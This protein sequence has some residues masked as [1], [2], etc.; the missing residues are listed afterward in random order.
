LWRLIRAG[1]IPAWG[2]PKC[3]R[4]CSKMGGP[5][6]SNPRLRKP[7]P[8]EELHIEWVRV[9]LATGERL[10]LDS[11][12]YEHFAKRGI[13]RR[14]VNR[15]VNLMVERGEVRLQPTADGVLVRP[16]GSSAV[17]RF[18]GS[19]AAAG[20]DIRRQSVRP[21]A[22]KYRLVSIDNT[23]RYRTGRN[24]GETIVVPTDPF[25]LR[26]TSPRTLR[27]KLQS[28]KAPYPVR[29]NTVDRDRLTLCRRNYAARATS[30][31]THGRAMAD[32]HARLPGC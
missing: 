19:L 14:E 4:S 16:A 6:M 9:R 23:R 22:T 1:V 7:T 27:S 31:V 3:Y 15:A 25:D 12:T 11:S 32:K 13:S 18:F 10:T 24:P 26:I 29:G 2:T 20:H 28:H 5:P 17:P 30:G 8:L 21:E